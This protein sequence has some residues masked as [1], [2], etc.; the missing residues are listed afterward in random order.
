[1][2]R[3]H[4]ELCVSSHPD[5]YVFA[6]GGGRY[7]DPDDLRR[8]VLYPA[9]NKAGIERKVARAYG[10]HLF[11]HSAGTQMHEV[12]G[13][14]QANAELSWAQRNRCYERRLRPPATGL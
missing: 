8:R 11:R 1:M 4:Q 5:D 14:L 3:E 6:N 13:D 12:T 9:M 7:Y 2:L 10:F